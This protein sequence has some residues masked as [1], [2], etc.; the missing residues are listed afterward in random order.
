MTEDHDSRISSLYRQSSQET[1][2]AQIDQAVLDRARKSVRSRVFSPFGNHWVAGGAVAGVAMLSVLL[3]LTV[4]QQPDSYT[5]EQDALAPSSEALP[6]AGKEAAQ[7]DALPSELPA[8]TAAKRAAPAVSKMRTPV[9]E[10]LP[11]REATVPEDESGARMQQKPAAAAEQSV[12]TT[13]PAET[14]YLQVGSFREQN[15]AVELKTKLSALGFKSV[16]QEV[17]IENMDVYHRVRVGPFTDHD[18]LKQSKR[19]LDELGIGTL[20]VKSR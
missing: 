11:D 7:S 6:E 3:I 15:H 17:S 16:I 14:W 8:A 10:K 18:A 1:P 20:T 4:P 13:A 5:P 19:K 12:S 2:S 9:P